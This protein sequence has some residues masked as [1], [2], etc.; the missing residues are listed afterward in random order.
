LKR[1]GQQSASIDRPL[2]VNRIDEVD[3]GILVEELFAGVVERPKPTA[4]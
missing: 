2:C 3:L 4:F 1:V